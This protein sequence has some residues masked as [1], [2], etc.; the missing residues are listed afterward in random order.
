V[1]D[2]N[3]LIP[4]VKSFRIPLPKAGAAHIDVDI[5][6]GESDFIVDNEYLGTVRVPASAA[7]KK[8]DFGLDE[9][10]LLKVVVESEPGQ[11]REVE[12][13]TRDTPEELRRAIE[14]DA[15]RQASGTPARERSAG[16][17]SSLKRMLGRN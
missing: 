1:I 8:I 14:E 11:A 13:A 5:Y 4:Q 2:K 12:L 10:C 17:F 7:G 6:Q 15:Q 3:T 9:E 16:L